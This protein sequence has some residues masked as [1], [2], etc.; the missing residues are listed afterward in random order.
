[1]LIVCP[2]ISLPYS[3][4]RHSSSGFPKACLVSFPVSVTTC[5]SGHHLW[6]TTQPL[7]MSHMDSSRHASHIQ[8]YCTDSMPTFDRA[9]G[10]LVSFT[11]GTTIGVYHHFFGITLLY[12][13]ILVESFTEARRLFLMYVE[14]FTL[15]IAITYLPQQIPTM[16]LRC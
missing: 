9:G 1:M 16:L 8:S 3:F 5:T 2:D 12:F 15:S 10:Q 4:G 7:D 11:C 13:K 6:K 14:I